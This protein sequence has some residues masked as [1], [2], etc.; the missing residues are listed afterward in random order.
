MLSFLPNRSQQGF[1]LIELMIGIVIMAIA[2]SLGMPSYKAWIQ[3]TRIRT[4]AESI[5][6]GIQLARGEAVKRNLRVQF[7]LR[8]ANSAWT[9]C[10]SP[11][12]PGACPNPDDATTIQSR[13]IGEGSS[14][15]IT[16]IPSD[17]LPF[18]FNSFGAM[19]SPAPSAANGL[20][21]IDVDVSTAVLSAA[22]SRDLRIVIGVG[23]SARLCDPTL[24]TS[25]TDPRRCPV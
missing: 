11:A 8:G 7:D 4:A 3:N 2:V 16:V 6:S 21:T 25:G 18:V 9:V 1:S 19:A 24:S 23:G 14:N 13:A 10:V 20:I 12:V 15:D 17:A 22:E 5:Q